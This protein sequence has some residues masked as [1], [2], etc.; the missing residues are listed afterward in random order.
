MSPF[1]VRNYLVAGESAP[2]PSQSG[3][4]LYMCNNLQ[5]SYPLPFT[6]TSPAVMGIHFTIEA[7]RR[8]GKKLSPR[9]A[10][11]YWTN[12]VIKTAIEQPAD[13]MWKKC[14]S[15]LVFFNWFEKGDHYHIGFV[16][17]FVKFF[18]FPFL[19]LWLILPLGMAGMITDSFRSRNALILSLI[20]LIYASTLILFF[21]NVRVRLPL[22]AILIPF[23]V[24]GLNDLNSHIK[25]SQLKNIAVYSAVVIL[26]L[27][28]NFF[29]FATRRT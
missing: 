15:T 11:R 27:S 12:E 24:S 18:K 3:F 17:D 29:L 28:L 25:K 13:F 4:N 6:S 20:F 5:Y 8:V 26:F 19:S 22:L 2:T 16:S 1:I 9:E 21:T 10:S 7:S 23:A 14:K